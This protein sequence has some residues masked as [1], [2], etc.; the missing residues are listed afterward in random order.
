LTVIVDV[1]RYQAMGRTKD[2]IDLEP[3]TDKFAAF[4]FE[5]KACDG[6]DQA[7]LTRSLRRLLSTKGRPHALIAKTVK[8]KGVSFMEE[9]N[10]WHYT[11][12]SD[13]IM[14]KALGELSLK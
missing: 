4:G 10:K 8:G 13:E 6:H 14:A 12:I 11:R 7:A 9:E 5:V 2:I 3:F 1:N